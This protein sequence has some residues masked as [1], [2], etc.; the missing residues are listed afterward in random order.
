M[1]QGL[2]TYEVVLISLR[3]HTIS[4]TVVLVALAIGV[5]L[6][7]GL[8]PNTL[9]S[10]LRDDKHRLQNQIDTLTDDKN[11]LNEKLNAAGEFDAQM[12]LRILHNTLDGKS[13]VFRTP[14]ASDEGPRPIQ[15]FGQR[16]VDQRRRAELCLARSA[17]RPRCG[18]KAAH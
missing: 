18:A 8:L 4:L 11:A 14:D 10:G 5:E 12:S 15:H 3:T 6:G 1:I 7:S 17:L 2:V 13:V 9:L 16:H